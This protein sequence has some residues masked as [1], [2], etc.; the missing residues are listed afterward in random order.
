M[1]GPFVV[2]IALAGQQ[3]GPRCSNWTQEKS[4]ITTDRS[5]DDTEMGGGV[6]GPVL[7]VL[8]ELVMGGLLVDYFVNRCPTRGR[9][10][11]A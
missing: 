4:R 7:R 1:N 2:G 5:H 3:G 11:V 9:Q 6:L 10:L 8:N